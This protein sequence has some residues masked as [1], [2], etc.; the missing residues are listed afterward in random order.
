MVRPIRRRYIAAQLHVH[1]T[2]LVFV[3]VFL[4]KTVLSLTAFKNYN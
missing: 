3:F 1:H 2:I 4:K